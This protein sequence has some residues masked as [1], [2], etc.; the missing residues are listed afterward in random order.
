MKKHYDGYRFVS[1]KVGSGE[2]HDMY[3]AQYVLYYLDHLYQ[4]GVPPVSILDPAVSDSTDK[5]AK[6]LINNHRAGAAYSLQNFVLGIINP[7]ERDTF[8]R[9]IVPSFC[10]EALFKED[11]VNACRCR[12]RSSTAS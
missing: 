3:N 2:Q 11:T 12:K 6:F 9:D 10:S 1:H 7:E 5:V 4:L 8:F